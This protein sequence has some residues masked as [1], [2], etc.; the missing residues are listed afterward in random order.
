MSE[1][2]S[3][4]KF[5]LPEVNHGVLKIEMGKWKLAGPQT[6]PKPYGGGGWKVAL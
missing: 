6:G 5:P 3:P 4:W 1:L 2:P